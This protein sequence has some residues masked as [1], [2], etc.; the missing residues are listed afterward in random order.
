M[1]QRIQAAATVQ[2]MSEPGVE[3]ALGVV[4]DPPFGPLVWGLRLQG[5]RNATR[6]YGPDLTPRVLAAAER[7]NIPVG[8]YGGSPGVL[9]TLVAVVERRY[10]RLEVAY[11]WSPPFRPLTAEEDDRV[12]REVSVSGARGAAG[13]AGGEG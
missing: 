10:P 12:V 7:E 5:L 1:R 13:R 8:F 3:M 6:V 9:G 2:E 4:S 11:R